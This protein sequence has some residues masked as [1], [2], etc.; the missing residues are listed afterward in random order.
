MEDEDD[1][2]YHCSGAMFKGDSSVFRVR[3]GQP[4]AFF[5][6]LAIVVQIHLAHLNKS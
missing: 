3:V 2:R 6:R 5:Q 1:D 4:A